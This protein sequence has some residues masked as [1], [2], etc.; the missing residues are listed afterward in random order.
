M[1]GQR[2]SDVSKYVTIA[3]V[4]CFFSVWKMKEN[5]TGVENKQFK[6]EQS[7]I[8]AFRAAWLL[9]ICGQDD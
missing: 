3:P 1:K 2:L 4:I 8:S 6:K 7:V 9:R 5:Q